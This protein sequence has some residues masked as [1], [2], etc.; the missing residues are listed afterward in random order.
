M[1]GNY[2]RKNW[3]KKCKQYLIDGIRLNGCER[4][5]FI[6]GSYLIRFKKICN[7]YTKWLKVIKIKL[8]SFF[9]K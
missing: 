1:I 7:K 3:S 5:L 8:F 9:N 6:Y 2:F 4:F